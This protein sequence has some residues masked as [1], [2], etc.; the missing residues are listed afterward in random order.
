M[1]Y[2]DKHN[3]LIK[4]DYLASPCFRTMLYYKYIRDYQYLHSTSMSYEVKGS[5]N[6]M[7]FKLCIVFFPALW[8]YAFA[9]PFAF[10]L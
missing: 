2:S 1:R 5:T 7:L 6:L 8:N 3:E 9:Y 4:Q 10:V